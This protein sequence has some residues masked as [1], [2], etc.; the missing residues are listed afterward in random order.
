LK[1]EQTAKLIY[2]ELIKRDICV[3]HILGDCLRITAGTLFECKA[4][5]IAF[6]EVLASTYYLQGEN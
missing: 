2:N 3:R 5:L 6:E 4:F 1:D